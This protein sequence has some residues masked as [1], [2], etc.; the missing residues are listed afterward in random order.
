[1]LNR[2]R[3]R[4][5][6]KAGRAA[7]DIAATSRLEAEKRAKAI[8]ARLNGGGA[9]GVKRDDD[10][11]WEFEDE[12]EED[13][14][15]IGKVERRFDAREKDYLRDEMRDW[16]DDVDVGDG[17]DHIEITEEEKKMVAN[18]K[19][20][21]GYS[22]AGQESDDDDVVIV[23]QPQAST[24]ASSSASGSK[25]KKAKVCLCKMPKW[26]SE[27]DAK[28]TAILVICTTKLRY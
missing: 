6:S 22:E 28:G 19:R 5:Q 3:L 16:R 13:K 20:K 9:A 14:P 27:G 24:S 1:M 23:E 26:F 11:D 25:A 17:G 8:E 4:T 21:M 15:E 10:E 18:L 7:R 12:D 2:N